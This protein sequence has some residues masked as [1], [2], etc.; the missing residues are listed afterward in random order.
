MS[1]THRV[2]VVED[3]DLIRESLVEYLA[4]QGYEAVGAENG[5]DA[6]DKLEAND[7]PPCLI[8]LDLMM[9]V[10]DGPTFREEQLR[11]PRLSDIPVVV[12]SAYRDVKVEAKTMKASSCLSKPLKLADL[13]RVVRQHCSAA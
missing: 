1:T 4:D 3:D 7:P 12:I 2:L 10:M 8:V 6:L 9:P 13:L 11:N 5:Q